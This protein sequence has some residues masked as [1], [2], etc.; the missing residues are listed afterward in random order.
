MKDRVTLLTRALTDPHVSVVWNATRDLARIG[1]DAKSALPALTEILRGYDPTSRLWARYAIAKITGET[2]KHLPVFIEALADK[3]G[4]FPGMASAALAGFGK[5]ART[6]VPLLIAELTESN[7]EY[8]W[9]AA[10]ALA[11]IGP[12]AG[13]AV[14]FGGMTPDEDWRHSILTHA[15]HSPSMSRA[16]LRAVPQRL[17]ETECT[18]TRTDHFLGVNSG[19]VR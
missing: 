1:P 4:I 11:N 10:G 3:K 13:T 7:A 8:R 5:E 18:R 19:P 17:I 6:A 12:D 16:C 14:S 9:S 2:T 15:R